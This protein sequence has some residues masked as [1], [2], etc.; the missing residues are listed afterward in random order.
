[1]IRH[2]AAPVDLAVVLTSIVQG[3][4]IRWMLGARGFSLVEEDLRL[5]EVQTEILRVREATQDD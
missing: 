5:F 4:A 1:M 3:V 2:S